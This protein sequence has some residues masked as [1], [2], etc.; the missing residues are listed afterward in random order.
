[1]LTNGS[2]LLE[3]VSF[4]VRAPEAGYVEELL[5]EDGDTVPVGAVLLKLKKGD[6]PA[7]AGTPGPSPMLQTLPL[8]TSP[9]TIISLS[10]FVLRAEKKAEAPKAA[11]DSSSSS[12]A[13]AE[14]P[15]AAKEAPKAAAPKAATP[16]P[17][18]PAPV[19][20]GSRTEERVRLRLH[21]SR[22]H[23]GTLVPSL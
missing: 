6:P 1:M 20:A 5:I 21:T 9:C 19:T 12:S 3:Q 18:P 17:P 7:G 15:P 22:H 23:S 13:A 8:L 11:D 14:A 2:L 16:P 4:D 10:F